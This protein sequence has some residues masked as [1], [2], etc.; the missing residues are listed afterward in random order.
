MT[1][2]T[3]QPPQHLPLHP[4]HRRE[5]G[6]REQGKGCVIPH[7]SAGSGGRAR[8][9]SQI[10]SGIRTRVEAAAK[11]QQ[12]TEQSAVLQWTSLTL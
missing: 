6:H 11:L 5:Q 1:I 2:E 9:A 8:I 7:R 3:E 10:Y 4:P 12:A